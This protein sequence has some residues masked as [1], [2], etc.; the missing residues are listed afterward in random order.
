MKFFFLI[1]VFLIM[2]TSVLADSAFAPFREG[3]SEYVS[4][5]EVKSARSVLKTNETKFLKELNGI[6]ESGKDLEDIHHQVERM[7]LS[8]QRRSI[9][10]EK[11][12]SLHEAVW[13]LAREARQID[14]A[15]Y[16]MIL[17]HLENTYPSKDDH[18]PLEDHLKLKDY[19]VR[20]AGL[21]RVYSELKRTD[22]VVGADASSPFPLKRF[23]FNFGDHKRIT[24]R[25]ELLHKFNPGEVKELARIMDFTLNVV[26]AEK[27]FTTIKYRN[28]EETLVLEH[29]QTE[30]YR[31]ALRL[32][33]MK[34]NE[35]ERSSN[36]SVKDIELLIAAVEAGVIQH[37]E[38]A[39]LVQNPD[40][41]LPEVPFIKKAAKFVGQI[42][43]TGLSSNPV[44]APYVIIPMILYNA[45][46]E[47]KKAG[48]AV[49]EDSFIF[50]APGRSR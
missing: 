30:Q 38:I 37:S 34:K 19:L 12:K 41:Y 16:R 43:I 17:A 48:T 23:H 4:E 36:K 33:R 31:L 50:E 20:K 21:K 25:E 22:E 40:F 13:T 42:A 45:Y 9:D 11:A 1:N 49:D 24:A 8:V 6:L 7:I 10:S 47:V 28:S 2:S 29:S 39:M 27:V 5:K 18:K 35:F 3:Q 15:F 26:D 32:M 14:D 46:V 44:T